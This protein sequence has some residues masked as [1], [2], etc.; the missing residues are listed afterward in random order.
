[1]N[2][3]FGI[4]KIDVTPQSPCRM[5]GYNRKG[6]WTD[7]LDPIEANASAVCV[8]L[9]PF[10]LIELDS[11]MVSKDFSLSV[12]NAVSSKTG[13]DSSNIV[14]ACIHTHSAPCY[15]KLAY[16]DTLPETE[17]TSDLIGLATEAAVSAWASRSKATVSMEMLGIEGLYGNRNVQGGPADKQ[18]SIFSFEDAQGGRPIGK[19]LFIS[20]HPTILNGKSAVLSADLIGHV[21]QRLER[22]YGCPVLCVNGTCGDVSTRFYRQGEGVAELERTANELCA[23]IESKRERAAL[24]VDTPRWGSINMKSVYD[25]KTDPDWI[26]MTNRIEAM[27][28][29]PMRDFLL[30]RQQLK[31]SMGKIELELPSQFAVIGNCIFITM[32]CDTCSTLGLDFKRAFSQYNVFVIGYANTYCNYLVPQE[33]YGKYF[34][35]YNSRTPR[36]VA[37]AFVARIIQ[38]VG[39][40]L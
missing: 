8:D 6:A 38:A 15:F 16:E 26:E 40:A 11:I 9:V 4:S 24:R 28:A 10:I 21:R 2:I 32:P 31:L 5:G 7:V 33:D 3:E 20:A 17:L 29:S 25:A 34:E 13:I 35:T 37:D 30:K 1:M 23:Q 14:V 27:D 36:G 18:V 39:A 19:M 12:K 22:K